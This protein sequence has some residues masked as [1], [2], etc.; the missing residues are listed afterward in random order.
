MKKIDWKYLSAR[1]IVTLKIAYDVFCAVLS[2]TLAFMTRLALVYLAED[3]SLVRPELPT[4]YIKFFLSNLGPFIGITLATLWLLGFYN[5]NRGAESWRP[6]KVVAGV[7][8]APIIW[9]LLLYYT[10]SPTDPFF[11]RGVTL[12]AW[13]YL[14]LL[15]GLPRI[16]KYL[17][18]RRMVV[19]INHHRR[20]KVQNVL[21]IGGAGYIGS[22]L[23]RDLLAQGFRIRIL[24]SFL[25]GE[26]PIR[27]ILNN[28]DLDIVRGDFRN[29]EAV[30]RAMKGM[31]AVVHLGGIV[32]D[33]ACSLD[34]DFTI[35]TNLSATILLA[36]IAKVFQIERFVFASSC[37]VYG[38]SKN[39]LL[40]EESPLNPV[41]LY[42]QTKIASEEVLLG[43]TNENFAPTIL[44]FATLFGLSPRPRFD[45]FV[46]LVTAKAVKEGK[47]AV[48]GGEQWRPFVHVRDISKTVSAVLHAPISKVKG[49]IFNVGS[50]KSCCTIAEAGAT[51]ARLVPGTTVERKDDIDDA[52][53]YRVSFAKLRNVLGLTLDVSLE[54]GIIEMRDAFI[55]GT[56]RDYADPNFSNLK[57]TEK[58]LSL[59]N[60]LESSIDSVYDGPRQTAKS[61]IRKLDAKKFA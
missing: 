53:D 10:L 2:L 19:D 44:R 12:F 56:L 7:S 52:R 34:D 6:L 60:Q 27:E 59:V 13:A 14:V 21:V 39:N 54:Q 48:F 58:V 9:S 33:P 32:G 22:Q 43:L 17:V 42:A 31:D 46:N 30:V 1:K 50:D 51:V 28:N 35:E 20:H 8:I 25:F 11:P 55:S 16:I 5:L 37:S 26:E 61:M 47:F 4:L 29:V 15:V 18:L 57:K 40:T 24:D 38:A 36:E 41:S 3:T 45:L 23:C 49:E